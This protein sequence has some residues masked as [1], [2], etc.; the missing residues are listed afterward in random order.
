MVHKRV[1]IPS[2]I[3]A[4]LAAN[5]FKATINLRCRAMSSF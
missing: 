1:I 4:A 5:V 2:N 3:N